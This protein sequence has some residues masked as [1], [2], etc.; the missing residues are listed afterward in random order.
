ME[1]VEHCD[2]IFL[3]EEGKIVEQGRY[4]EMMSRKGYFFKFVQGS[5]YKTMDQIATAIMKK[6]VS[7]LLGVKK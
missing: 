3:I 5:K 2:V 7:R 1:A 6:L 4:D